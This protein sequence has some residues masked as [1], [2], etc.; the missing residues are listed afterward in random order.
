[1]FVDTTLP[2]GLRSV[3]KI[4]TA[5]ADALEWI[6]KSEGVSSVIQYL[7]NFLLAGSPGSLECARQLNTL[8][9]FQSPGSPSWHPKTGRPDHM[10]DLPLHRDRHHGAKTSPPTGQAG[11]AE[12][13]CLN[14]DEKVL[15]HEERT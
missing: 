6:V 5:V 12:C 3:P 10:P 1:M 7:E 2:F 11:G 15:M 8:V 13:T 4:F 14:L 9:F